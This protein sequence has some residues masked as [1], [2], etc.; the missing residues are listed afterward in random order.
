MGSILTIAQEVAGDVRLVSPA[1]L[2]DTTD[3]TSRALLR[4]LHRVTRH[5]I[6]YW[7]WP[8]LHVEK[9]F[10]SVTNGAQTASVATDML[11]IVPGTIYDRTNHVRILGP[12]SVNEWQ[13][14]Q[15]I[16]TQQIKPA[17]M[18]RGKGTASLYLSSPYA[19]GAT[20]AYEYM[21]NSVGTASDG[22]T[23]RAER[24]TAN[25]DLT[26]WSDELI[27]LGMLWATQHRDGMT[28]GDDYEAFK[29]LAHDEMAQT[30]IGDTLSMAPSAVDD[31]SGPYV[32]ESSWQI[33]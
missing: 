19:V 29:M 1:D 21:V 15:A 23:R 17:Y 31:L 12:L 9:T 18:M 27:H 6:T 4:A 20:I 11:R 26:Y 25:T 32:P 30:A 28:E 2:F 33:T 8:A 22:T 24:F 10:T 5:L 16:L 3:D 13:E 14:R 7:S